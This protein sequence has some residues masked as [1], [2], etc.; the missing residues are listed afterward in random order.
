M[1]IDAIIGEALIHDY[2]RIESQML[3]LAGD[4][5]YRVKQARGGRAAAPDHPQ[6][7]AG[8]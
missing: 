3:S 6:A 5:M 1:Q 8:G 2:E 7:L 4:A